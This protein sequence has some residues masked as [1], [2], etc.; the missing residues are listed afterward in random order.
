[1]AILWRALPDGEMKMKYSLAAMLFAMVASTLFKVVID[2]E[3]DLSFCAS[4]LL[5]PTIIVTALSLARGIK[6]LPK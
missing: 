3:R 5:G 6:E 4:I 1:M 2:G